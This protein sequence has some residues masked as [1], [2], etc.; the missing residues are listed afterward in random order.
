MKNLSAAS[1]PDR[2]AITPDRQFAAQNETP[3]LAAPFE[4]AK[5]G[6]FCDAKITTLSRNLQ[7]KTGKKSHFY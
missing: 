1:G 7:P 5:Q 4:P 2:E 6:V 3:A